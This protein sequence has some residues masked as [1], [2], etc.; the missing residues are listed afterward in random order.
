MQKEIG[1]VYICQTS[2]ALKR[3]RKWRH[4]ET[5]SN[6]LNR[7]KN[8]NIHILWAR[9]KIDIRCQTLMYS[10]AVFLIIFY[11]KE[12]KIQIKKSFQKLVICFM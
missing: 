8:W 9:I 12:V 1:K 11:L 4:H 7:T 3:F 6:A 10:N 5:L 2:K